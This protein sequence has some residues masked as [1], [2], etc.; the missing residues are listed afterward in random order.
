M[1]SILEKFG[2]FLREIGKSCY[3]MEFYR[4]VRTRR[5]GRAVA[6][7]ASFGALLVILGLL[8]FGP[9]MFGMVGDAKS[10]VSGHLPDGA[11]F[12]VQKGVF[13]TN[14]PV[15]NDFGT[16]GTMVMDT[17]LDGKVFPDDKYPKADVFIGSE[18]VWFRKNEVEQRRY[19]MSDLPD[20]SLT[21]SQALSWMGSY[22]ILAVA[23]FLLLIA[24]MYSVFFLVSILFYVVFMSAL[25]YFAGRLWKVRLDFGQWAAA[26]FHA[27][28][29]PV[30]VDVALGTFGMDIPY[31]F[32]FIYILFIGAVIADERSNP[33]SGLV[34]VPPPLVASG[35]AAPAKKLRV[36]QKRSPRK[37]KPEQPPEAPPEV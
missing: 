13:S 27:V 2:R 35:P 24:I 36:V 7:L 3:D 5:L 34:S 6:Y 29:L 20:V 31:A 26:G 8:F 19:M 16:E 12:A 33:T 4:T 15:P 11:Q 22:G 23:G 37:K 32:S 30:L 28:T 25:A 17:S 21:K 9:Q 14:V 18:A 10:W 1:K